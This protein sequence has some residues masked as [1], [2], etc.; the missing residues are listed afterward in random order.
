MMA[1]DPPGHEI[2]EFPFFTFLFADLHAHLMAIPFTLLAL[3]LALALVL[4][5]RSDRGGSRLGVGLH[6]AALLAMLGVTV[7][8]LRTINAWD[9]PT[10][11][12]IGGGAVFLAAWFRNGG[13]SLR[14]LVEA[15][16]KSGAVFLVGYVVYLPYHL[17]YET[18]FAS[19]EA[20][21]NQTVLWQFLAI[22]GLFVFVIGSY[23]VVEPRARRGG[24]GS[25]RYGDGRRT[26]SPSTTACPRRTGAGSP[27]CGRLR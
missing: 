23:A 6:E 3:G 4:G 24:R 18:F 14:V 12:L 20:T 11:L 16:V 1:P 19:V 9:F 8:A 22:A 7:G 5:A 13:L 27:R 21:T 26:W 15:A 10:Y 2:T 25:M 17:S